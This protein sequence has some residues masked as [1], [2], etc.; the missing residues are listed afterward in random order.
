MYT[1][2]ALKHD[3]RIIIDW[4]SDENL[5]HYKYFMMKNVF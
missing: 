2:I 4:Q 3:D 5:E 1:K